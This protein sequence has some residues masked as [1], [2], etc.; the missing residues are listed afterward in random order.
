MD[1]WKCIIILYYWLAL[2]SFCV[3]RFIRDEKNKFSSL[4]NEFVSHSVQWAQGAIGPESLWLA[5]ALKFLNEWMGKEKAESNEN[6]VICLIKMDPTR[7]PIFLF[8]D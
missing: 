7:L 2:G 5:Q 8:T 6:G 1:S 3:F 4:L